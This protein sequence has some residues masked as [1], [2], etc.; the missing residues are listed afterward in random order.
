MEVYL[1][2]AEFGP[3]VY[4]AEAAARQFFGVGADRLSRVQASRL[5]AVL[6][7]P[8]VYKAAKPGRYV[9]RRSRQ[10]AG[11]AGTVRA[12]GLAACVRR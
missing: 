11:N 9:A 7:R 10:I 2:V 1:N 12:E 4:G 6:P 3:G 5:A 8:L